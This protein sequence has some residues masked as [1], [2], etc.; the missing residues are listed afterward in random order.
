MN[1]LQT[2]ETRLRVLAADDHPTNRIVI[3]TIL[4]LVSADVVSVEDGAQAVDAFRT[5]RFDIVLMDLQMPVM[6]GLTATRE[7]RR[8]EVE[9]GL[10]RTPLLVVTAN[11]LSEHLR[12]AIA[13]GADDHMAKPVTPDG[14]LAAIDKTIESVTGDANAS[15]AQTGLC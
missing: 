12:A 4:E 7:I 5:G 2:S 13:A 11:T 9:S 14:L 15:P 1:Q 10:R 6:D 8:L 3:E